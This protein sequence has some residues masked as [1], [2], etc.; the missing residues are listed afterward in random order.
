MKKLILTMILSALLAGNISACNYIP[1]KDIRETIEGTNLV[2]DNK[3]TL[4]TEKAE[5]AKKQLEKDYQETNEYYIKRESSENL[6]HLMSKDKDKI[7]IEH[8]HYGSNIF[9]VTTFIDNSEYQTIISLSEGIRT[10]DIYFGFT[11]DSFGYVMI[12]N[13]E[14]YSVSSMDDI[15]LACILK[16][17]D[18]GK[19]WNS[20]E[21]EDFKVSNGR[22]YISAACF[23]TDDVGF[24]TSRYTN[25]DHFAPRTFWTTDGGKTWT[26]M[27]K[28]DI[29]NVLD[30]FGI[31]GADFST[32]VSDVTIEDNVYTITVR[33]CHG[34]SLEIDG[35]QNS[36]IYI[37]Y[38]S[39]DLNNWT[40]K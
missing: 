19:T 33:I 14:G 5:G 27:P 34:Y 2:I 26:R 3:N 12:F 35:K 1:E 31:D 10:P 30:I 16:T 24:F 8:E 18:G 11:S 21:Y 13:M 28:L 9:Y 37:Q 22:E 39:E 36:E 17:S 7:K 15:E 20:T 6:K 40:L 38:Q 25:T 4:D 29:P 32:E 23:F